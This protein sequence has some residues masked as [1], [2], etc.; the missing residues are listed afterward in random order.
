MIRGGD[1]AKGTCLLQKGV[2]YIVVEREFVNPGKGGAFARVKM[3]SLKDGSVLTQTIPTQ[4]EVEDAQVDIHSCQYQYADGEYYH[5]MDNNTYDQFEVPIAGMEDKKYYLKEGETY[6]LL[7]WEGQVIDIKIPY[8]IVFTVVESENYVKGDTVSGATK[9]VVT[10][11]GLTVRVP[12]F[13]KQGEK[14]LVNTE[15]NE[16]VERVND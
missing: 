8:K 11:T 12:L 15:T 13:I 7:L 1:I 4:A 5:F 3:K 16:Y 6:D 9:P 2:P 10:E 14:I